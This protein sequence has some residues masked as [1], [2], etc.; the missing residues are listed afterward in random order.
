VTNVRSII[1][2]IAGIT[3]ISAAFLLSPISSPDS[4]QDRPDPAKI[5]AKA[6]AASKTFVDAKRYNPDGGTAVRVTL[7]LPS[8]QK[9]GYASVTECEQ[10][11]QKVRPSG[12]ASCTL[13]DDVSENKSD[14]KCEW[15]CTGIFCTWPDGTG[16]KQFSRPWCVENKMTGAGETKDCFITDHP[17]YP[18]AN[19]DEGLCSPPFKKTGEMIDK[20]NKQ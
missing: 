15:G 8:W 6:F 17:D 4:D 14:P 12:A 19:L 9:E 13:L 3:G 11:W 18:V 16:G 20:E 2:G 7:R 10:A 1:Y 5:I